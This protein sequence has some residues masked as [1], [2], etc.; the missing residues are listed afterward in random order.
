MLPILYN[1]PKVKRDWDVWSLSHAASHHKIIQK[2][3]ALG[4]ISLPFYQF[5]P[6]NL[7][8]FETFL[9]R[10]QKAH[11]DMV[12]ALGIPGRDLSQLDLKNENQ[13][14]AWIDQHA[15]EHRDV[16]TALGV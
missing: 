1:V 4:G 8:D 9:E 13:L 10:N 12:N 6:M 14:R 11:N 5:D 16:E 7:A 15:K 2:I 3:V